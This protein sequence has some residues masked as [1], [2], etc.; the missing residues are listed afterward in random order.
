MTLPAH[1]ARR[2]G[3][4]PGSVVTVALMPEGIH[5]MTAEGEGPSDRG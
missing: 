4:G 5:V 2:T 3:L 1:Y